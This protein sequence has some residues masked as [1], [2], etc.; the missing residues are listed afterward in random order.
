MTL[1]MPC[2]GK[3][4]AL[5]LERGPMREPFEGVDGKRVNAKTVD[6]IAKPGR[7]EELR[8]HICQSVTPLLRLR[9]EF[10]RAIVLTS[11]KEPRR[12]VVITFW[13]SE[14]HTCTPWEESPQV[15]KILSPLVDVWPKVRT[16]KVDI[17]ETIETDEQLMSLTAC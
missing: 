1:S 13:S 3:L 16:Y 2:R 14:E 11:D 7:T 8:E 10:I 5:R 17:A 9:T 6:F 15:R 4:G 12:V